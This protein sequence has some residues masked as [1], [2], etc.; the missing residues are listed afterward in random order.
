LCLHRL[1]GQYLDLESGLSYNRFRYY[2]SSLGRF[3]IS[4]PIGLRGGI[5]T[6]IY[7]FNNPLY[8]IDL[9]G[10]NGNWNITGGQDG[11]R[12]DGGGEMTFTCTC[13]NGDQVAT[14]TR[15]KNPDTDSDGDGKNDDPSKLLDDILKEL[16]KDYDP[17]LFCGG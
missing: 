15:D 4:D 14:V 17:D 3:I 12:G 6:Y 7:V 8:W 9:F 1:P 2:S 10:L 13:D 16:D 11:T 5:N